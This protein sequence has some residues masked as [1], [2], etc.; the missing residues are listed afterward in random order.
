MLVHAGKYIRQIKNTDNTLPI[1]KH[2]P[3]I[4]NNAKHSKTKL[5]W[6]SRLLRHS[7]EMRWAYS[8]VCPSPHGA[9]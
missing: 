6:F 1:T 3:E 7:E 9:R 4:A 8:T 2:N 5:P